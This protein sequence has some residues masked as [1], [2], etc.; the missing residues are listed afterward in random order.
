M[1][2]LG[3]ICIVFGL[4]AAF[5]CLMLYAAVKNAGQ[6]PRITEDMKRE[7]RKDLR[8][9]GLMAV[10]LF[11]I[12]ASDIMMSLRP[13]EGKIKCSEYSVKEIKSSYTDGIYKEKEYIIYYKK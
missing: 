1:K 5:L 3:I 11:A 2:L 4:I 13:K 6:D 7:V 10:I 9:F 12:G 8:F